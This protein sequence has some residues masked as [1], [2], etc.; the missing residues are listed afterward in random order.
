MEIVSQESKTNVFLGEKLRG[1][2]RCLE[3]YWEIYVETGIQFF[4]VF[5]ISTLRK[6]LE[7]RV[8]RIDTQK[9]C[10]A[11]LTFSRIIFDPLGSMDGF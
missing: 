6:Y 2:A 11:D 10:H 9:S 7:A 1:L 4:W 3:Q 5:T 8:T